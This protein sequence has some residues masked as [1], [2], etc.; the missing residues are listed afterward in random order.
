METL[1]CERGQDVIVQTDSK[2]YRQ[3]SSVFKFSVPILLEATVGP[4]DLINVLNTM[5]GTFCVRHWLM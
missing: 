1:K 5:C 3:H 4:N 2:D